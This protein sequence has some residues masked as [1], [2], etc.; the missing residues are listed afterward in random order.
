MCCLVTAFMVGFAALL[1]RTSIHG[2]IVGLAIESETIVDC[3]WLR[4]C[5]TLKHE[6]T[7]CTLVSFE[8][9]AQ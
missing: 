2:H 5:T 3:V 8:N 6:L 7:V 1:N 9:I 4:V